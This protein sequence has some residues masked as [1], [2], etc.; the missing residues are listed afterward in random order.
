MFGSMKGREGSGCTATA[1]EGDGIMW[2]VA[3]SIFIMY[4]LQTK[5][6][7]RNSVEVALPTLH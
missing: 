6:I 7:Y 3:W 5:G 1:W 2:Y 4:P